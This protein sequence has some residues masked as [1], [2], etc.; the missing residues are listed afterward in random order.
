VRAVVKEI[1][2]TGQAV[3]VTDD[4]KRLLV[5]GVIGGE[6]VLVRLERK[7]KRARLEKILTEAPERVA[8]P[9]PV[10]RACG[11]CDL[12]HVSGDARR[13]LHV[14]HL[15]ELLEHAGLAD[16][17][18]IVLHAATAELRYRVRAR[19]HVHATGSKAAVGYRGKRSHR[20]VEVEGC[21][22][23]R[24][25]LESVIEPLSSWL[26]S[27][28]GDGEASV[29]LGALG[30][31]V[32][33]LTW[34]G[35]LAA[36]VFSGAHARVADGQ[37]AGVRIWSEGASEPARFGDPSPVVKA[38]DGLPLTMA[39]G[40]FGQA[41]DWGGVLLAERAAELVPRCGTLVELYAGSGTL[42]VAIAERAERF[43][44]VERSPDAARCLRDNLDV[45][46]LSAKVV[47]AGA[48]TFTLPGDTDVVVLD[49]PR[50]G[51]AEVM[52]RLLGARPRQ[53]VYVSCD[54][55]T[56]A[57]DLAMLRGYRVSGLEVFELFP[58]T[59]HFETIALLTKG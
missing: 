41:S 45:R 38:F 31:P 52:E 3:A 12:M 46:A 49:P 1:S 42:S 59:S 32:I 44:A 56:L 7:G 47:V 34:R 26:A 10:V 51:A 21:A 18:E 11:G 23:L 28:H 22:V 15:R 4:G 19:L 6:Q 20:L 33:E 50:A 24:P 9:C 36:D 39:P 8:A 35:T 5:G 54:A 17:P 30:R 13:A 25:E 40:S 37:W 55:A 57:R 2:P 58:Q 29:A 16:L 43:I 14:R 48:E 53:I 27:S